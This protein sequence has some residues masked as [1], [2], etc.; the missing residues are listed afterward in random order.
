MAARPTFNLRLRQYQ[1]LG[2][3]MGIIPDMGITVASTPDGG[4]L[5]ATFTTLVASS[6]PDDCEVA[7]EVWDGAEWVEGRD[8]RFVLQTQDADDRDRAQLV[9]ITGVAL[10]V[11]LATKAA[12]SGVEPYQ[13][14]GN[15]EAAASN[16]AVQVSGKTFTWTGHVLGVGDRVRVKSKG[17]S[18]GLTSGSVYYV[19]NP[20]SS[21]FQLSHTPT[22]TILSF[23]SASNV[24]LERVRTRIV[25]SGSHSF[26]KNQAVSVLN[27]DGSGLTNGSTYYV[28]NPTAS[29]IQ[30]AGK[31]GGIPVELASNALTVYRYLDGQ[32]IWANATPGLI[33]ENALLEARDRG[34]GCDASGTP[35]VTMTWS[36][37][38]DSNS[39]A[40]PARV[41]DPTIT[42]VSIGFQPGTS[43]WDMMTFLIDNGWAEFATQG[44]SFDL[45]VPNSGYDWGDP[46]GFVRRLGSAAQQVQITKDL[47]DYRTTDI[48]RG[49]ANIEERVSVTRSAWGVLE[50][51]V[52]ASGVTSRTA[53]IS[54]GK[55]DL[56]K[57]STPAVGYT[58]TEAGAEA[59][60]LPI[61]D[62]QRGDWIQAQVKGVWTR[63]RVTQWTLAKDTQGVVTVTTLME[64][65]KRALLHKVAKAA[66]RANGG[67]VATTT[68]TTPHEADKRKAA[69]PQQLAVT[70]R[71]AAAADKSAR[72]TITATWL[73]VTSDG[74]GNDLVGAN[75]EVT[76][77]TN[78]QLTG[79]VVGTTHD[80]S[81]DLPAHA[82]GTILAVSVR[83]QSSTGTWGELTDEV[84]Y[85]VDLPEDV[86]D[87]PST[88]LVSSTLGSIVVSWDGNLVDPTDGPHAPETADALA[89]VLVQRSTDSTTWT[90]EAQQL[91]SAGSVTD[92]GLTVGTTYQYRLIAVSQLGVQSAPSPVASAAVVAVDTAQIDADFT[93]QVNQASSDAAAASTAAS[94]AQTTANNAATTAA[95]A[96]TT[97]NNASTAAAAA[98]TTASGKN[99][100]TYSTSAASG[101]PSKDGDIWWRVD[102][103]SGAVTGW[104]VGSGGAWVS[105]TLSATVIPN[106]DAGK[107]TTGYLAAAR[108]QA[109]TIT[110]AMIAATTI[111]A[112]NI[113]ANTITAGQIA[114]STITSAQIAANTIQAGDIAANTITAAQLSATAIDAMTITGATFRT[115]STA[116]TAGGV[117]IDSTG[118]HGYNASGVA[119]FTLGTDGALSVT[120]ATVSGAITAT[121]GT[122][123]GTLTISGS[124]SIFT[125]STASGQASTT[126]N[127]G[128]V[129]YKIAGSITA[130]YGKVIDNDSTVVGMGFNYSNNAQYAIVGVA[131]STGTLRM[132]SQGGVQIAQWD[133]TSGAPSNSSL[134]I[135][136]GLDAEIYSGDITFNRYTA[137]PAGGYYVSDFVVGQDSAGARIASTGIRARQYATAQCVPNSTD[138][139]VV[140][141][142]PDGTFGTLNGTLYQQN[143]Y[144]DVIST[145]AVYTSSSGHLG[146]TASS[147]RVKDLHQHLRMDD[148][149]LERWL[150]LPVWEFSYKEGVNLAPEDKGK[151]HHGF[152]AEEVHEAGFTNLVY[153]EER[154]GHPNLGQVQ[155]FAYEKMGVYNHMA[156][157]RL[158]ARLTELEQRVAKMAA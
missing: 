40:W 92:L 65:K 64:K 147:R 24:S 57:Y 4:T 152:V 3:V 10:P 107:I 46:S 132:R 55:N 35:Q 151:R 105:Q 1:P 73:P 100:V 140:V 22:G 20:T 59:E 7:V 8:S 26:T 94:N 56:A 141:M 95:A 15:V 61:L 136:S 109:G 145:R 69:Q 66:R 148:K 5:Q 137:N 17:S 77:R 29:T 81:I 49:E 125:G 41:D 75:Y 139:V 150:G 86:P 31:A 50:Q 90:T 23:G 119:T 68:S 84:E 14:D 39:Y 45:F 131:T 156:I 60:W 44:R 114:A 43:L 129:Q 13:K 52:T 143:V 25:F 9:T 70:A 103:T 96:Q 97:A 78:G 53:A 36:A 91:P 120:G 124:G 122:I 87:A 30:L 153:Y 85:I 54:Y 67:R 80:T 127:T 34:W 135:G 42:G 133:G 74:D 110:G 123:T 72:G 58:V 93:A 33:T 104:W 112:G 142:N 144:S 117:Q 98:Q 63:L 134:T 6:L 158:Y 19:R 102:A 76:V 32:R 28:V 62:Y 126:F 106:L 27:A 99:A 108:I 38:A 111:T 113:A 79:T 16:T 18:K 121:S 154:E 47:T 116:K 83:A 48:V 146:T 115:A 21:T 128:G 149:V 89:Y 155:G 157:R 130:T 12:L 101:A 37:A 51:Y 71:T 88:P 82:A 118:L 11:W 2:S 138:R